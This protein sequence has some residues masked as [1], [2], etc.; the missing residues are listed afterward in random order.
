MHWT[1]HKQI[2]VSRDETWIKNI[3]R[4][5]FNVNRFRW[6]SLYFT[7]STVAVSLPFIEK[8]CVFF[9]AYCLHGFNSSV[10]SFTASIST[11]RPLEG[12][13]LHL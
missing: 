3:A 2:R 8:L 9:N 12:M 11:S 5:D 1:H 6:L 7:I 10:C 13:Y 4:I